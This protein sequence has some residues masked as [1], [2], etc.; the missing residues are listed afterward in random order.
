MNIS[1]ALAVMHTWMGRDVDD[2][3]EALGVFQKLDSVLGIANLAASGESA[4]DGDVSVL[5]KQID[6]ARV[7]KDYATADRLR[8]E[9][10]ASGYEVRST[11]DGTVA[12]QKLA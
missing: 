11:P 1:S 4:E 7:A 5:C 3:K 2:A 6:E 9:L 12:H 8:D 10:V